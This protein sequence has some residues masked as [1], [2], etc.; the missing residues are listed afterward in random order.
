MASGL[1]FAL[2]AVPLLGAALGFELGLFV[3]AVTNW[4]WWLFTVALSLP[5]SLVSLLQGASVGASAGQAAA[6]AVRAAP[7][8]WQAAA[9][10]GVLGFWAFAVGV[11]YLF[12]VRLRVM[13]ARR[14][15]RGRFP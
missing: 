15:G 12:K 9:T 5:G 3:W 14:V 4:K 6:A 11:V 13:L 7:P 8:G 1:A 10:F 2:G